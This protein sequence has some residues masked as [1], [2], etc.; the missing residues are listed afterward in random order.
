MK[1]IYLS[2]SLLLLLIFL[3]GC[4]S[5][6]K[7]INHFKNLDFPTYQGVSCEIR[8]E[9]ELPPLTYDVEQEIY[10][11]VDCDYDELLQII[12]DVIYNAIFTETGTEATIGDTY[13][14]RIEF[15][16]NFGD[17]LI[18]NIYNRSEI[19]KRFSKI[20][21]TSEIGDTHRAIVTDENIVNELQMLEEIF[22]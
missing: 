8:V 18:I 17:K 5:K 20:T 13:E 11:D 14:V 7:T 19:T 15:V 21:I 3:T 12:E 22:K 16:N 2:V 6:V 1:R 4:I 9:Q 10:E